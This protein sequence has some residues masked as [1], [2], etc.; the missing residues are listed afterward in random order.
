M[1]IL[2]QIIK[3][4]KLP[5]HLHSTASILYSVLKSKFDLQEK[6][7]CIL[8]LFIAC[9]IEDIHGFLNKITE[10]ALK[11]LFKEDEEKIDCL[12]YENEALNY[13]NFE[14]DFVNIYKNAFAMSLLANE[15]DIN[16]SWNDCIIKIKKCLCNNKVLERM[17]KIYKTDLA[18]LKRFCN[19][20]SLYSI[21][22]NVSLLKIEEI[23]KLELDLTNIKNIMETN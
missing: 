23:K 5:I 18:S 17:G 14:F 6:D 1:E 2:Y 3:A 21:N 19:E 12:K 7:L 9:K 11:V 16:V 10:N 15:H 22:N 8:S 13:L 20:I 4:L